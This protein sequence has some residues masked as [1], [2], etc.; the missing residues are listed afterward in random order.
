MANLPHKVVLIDY[1]PALFAPVG[2]EAETLARV[3]ASWET[4]QL[5][6][7][8]SVLEV[9]KDADVIIVQ[10]VRPLLTREVISQLTRARCL[11]RAG[12]GY[13]SIDYKAATEYGIMVCNTPTY[14]TDD[15]ADHALSLML[16][17]LR[18]LA[19]LD[20][21]MRRGE[22]AR[23]LAKPTRRLKGATLGIIGLGRIG[24]TV[25]RRVKGWE[26]TVLAYD[27]YVSQEKADELGVQ[28]VSLEE[29]LG[30]VEFLTIHCLL[31]DETHHLLSRREFAAI[32]PGLVLVN[33]ARGPIIDE[34]ALVEALQDG[35]VWV[36]GLD[37]TEQEPL[38]ADSPLLQMDNVILTP[39]VAANSPESR[40]D[41]YR[42]MCEISTEV[43]N[44]RVPPFVVN[45]EVLSHLR[46]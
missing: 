19:R 29:L 26:M 20:A 33:T 27:P 41:L 39:H 22:Y 21:A 44:G 8:K 28:M 35:R 37:V 12:A 2:N 18:H 14:C 36:A 31:N 17:C 15:V 38:P 7:P 9:A 23:H 13:D 4:Y 32:Q 6:D 11:I 45:P 25:A 5:R 3:G 10:S 42:L 30:R 46:G 24:S 43:V 34:A 1:D 40:V 16:G